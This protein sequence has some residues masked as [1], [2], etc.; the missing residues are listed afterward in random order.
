MR[1][2]IIFRVY[3]V[4]AGRA[5]DSCFGAFRTRAEAEARI[6][7]LAA[8]VMDGESWA[9]RYHNQGFVIREQVVSTDFEIPARPKPRD[10][11]VART[12]A[13]PNGP[14]VWDS[15]VVEVLRRNGPALE[16][17]AEYVRDYSMLSTFEPFRQGER[18]LALISRDYTKTAVL[19]LVSGEVIAE[20]TESVPGGGFCPVGFYVP[21]WWDVHDG[22]IIPGSEFWD[23]DREWPTGDFGFVW[24]CHWGDDSSW[25]VQHLDLRRVQEGIIARDERFGYVKLAT[26]AYQSPCVA[27]PPVDGP[28]PPPDFIQVQRYHGVTS[29]R[30]AVALRFDLGSGRVNGGEHRALMPDDR[31]EADD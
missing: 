24:G 16:R 15:T 2:D 28:S 1:G 26:R 7:E 18:E 10:K 31:D 9:A 29:V 4:H 14:G 12:T 8:K 27:S 20:E 25:K 5:A 17:V 21:D 13:K 19:D 22:S 23:S 30:F 3:G 6:A 11:Y